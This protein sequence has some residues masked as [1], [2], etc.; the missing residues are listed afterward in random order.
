MGNLL[1]R[2]I[3]DKVTHYFP[4][5]AGLDVGASGMQGWRLEQE[6]AHVSVTMENAP[7]HVLVGVFDGHGG[8][9]AS[10]WA[11]EHIQGAVEATKSWRDYVEG[12]KS[13]QT[14]T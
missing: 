10:A 5:L 4:N 7:D 3:K 12:G 1:D 8:A 6:D 14:A 2:P 9:G 11:S 13:R